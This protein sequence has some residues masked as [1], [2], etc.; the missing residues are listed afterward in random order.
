M[1]C[2]YAKKNGEEKIQMYNMFHCSRSG[3]RIMKQFQTWVKISVSHEI[4]VNDKITI[5][6]C[7]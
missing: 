7:K 3:L 5:E 2:L 1:S 4:V 6:N